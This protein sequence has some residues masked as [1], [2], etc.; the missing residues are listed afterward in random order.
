M[1]PLRRLSTNRLPSLL[2]LLFICGGLA[3]CATSKLELCRAPH[4]SLSQ[5]SVFDAS[6]QKLSEAPRENQLRDR[7][8]ARYLAELCP[9]PITSTAIPNSD[10]QNHA[11]MISGAVSA[12]FVIGAHYDRVGG[13]SG[14]ADNWSGVV[15]LATL[16]NYFVQNPPHHSLEFVMFG[17]EEDLMR[18]AEAHIRE[19]GVDGVVAMFNLDTLGVGRPTID[20]RTDNAIEC[21]ALKV[22]AAHGIETRSINLSTSSGDWEPYQRRDIPVLNL[23]SLNRNTQRIVHSYRDH[24][25]AVKKAD[26]LSAGKIALDTIRA[27]DKIERD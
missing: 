14:I 6:F 1:K 9:R 10:Q 19:D 4:L 3:G 2:A 22:A 20:T 23:H 18:G 27:L 21:T 16:L 17:E 24:E 15:L 26:W 12:R 25:R 5:D 7:L 13:G 8:A 11:C